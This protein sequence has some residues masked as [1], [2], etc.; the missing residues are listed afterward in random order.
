MSDDSKT[1]EVLLSVPNEMEAAA[2]VSALA[3]NGVEAMMVGG[4]TSSFNSGVPGDTQVVVRTEDLD[5]AKQALLA[6]QQEEHDIDW[7]SV[8]FGQPEE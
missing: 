3:E 7:D 1:P 4:F 5:R 8:D 6:I 2:I